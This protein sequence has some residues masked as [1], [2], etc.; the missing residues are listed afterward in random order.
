M[1]GMKSRPKTNHVIADSM[2]PAFAELIDKCFRSCMF[3]SILSP[4][5]SILPSKQS[6]YLHAS[7]NLHTPSFILEP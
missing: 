4:S 5:T 7:S 6:T 2:S 1:L 3:L